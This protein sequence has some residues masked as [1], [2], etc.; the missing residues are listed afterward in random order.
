LGL[1]I[2]LAGELVE[3]IAAHVGRAA[4]GVVSFE[5]ADAPPG[6]TA[7]ARVALW[8]ARYRADFEEAERRFAVDRRAIG[9]AIAFEAL[10]DPRTSAFGYAARFSGPGKVHYREQRFSEGDPAAKQVE[11]LGLMPHLGMA[12]RR[13]AL[14][15]PAIAIAYIGAIMTAFVRTDPA[16]SAALRCADA[17]LA[18]LYTAWK[19]SDFAHRSLAAP[20]DNAAGDWT[21]AH[22][23][24]LT[25]ALGA[26]PASLC[27]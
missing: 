20:R 9:A 11:D 16:D 22:L 5:L 24:Y 6:P 1:A 21:N 14:Q 25:N 13:A 23:A 26:P 18:T 27:P 2:V 17:H 19:P 4:P 10:A 12:E 3:V 15:R 7:E 8:L